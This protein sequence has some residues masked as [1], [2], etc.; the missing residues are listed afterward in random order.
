MGLNG[1]L[2][3]WAVRGDYI[4]S[5]QEGILSGLSGDPESV[6]LSGPPPS[7]PASLFSS[8]RGAT[9][10]AGLMAVAGTLVTGPQSNLGMGVAV[11]WPCAPKVRGPGHQDKGKGW[12][13][14]LPHMS[15]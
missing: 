1:I 6:C 7:D 13:G 12:Q 11:V 3:R 14:G 8:S 4:Y 2:A 5:V 10:F 15:L 9:I